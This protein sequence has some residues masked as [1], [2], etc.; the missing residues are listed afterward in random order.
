[1]STVIDLA[2]LP[3]TTSAQQSSGLFEWPYRSVSFACRNLVVIAVAISRTDKQDT[4][5]KPFWYF[6]ASTCCQT[7]SGSQACSTYAISFMEPITMALSSL[8]P[9][10]ISWAQLVDCQP[11]SKEFLY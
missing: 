7:I 9:E 2:T 4:V 10:Q 1:M 8:S 11:C 6:G 5:M 3:V